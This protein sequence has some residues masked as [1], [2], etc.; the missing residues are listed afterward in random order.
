MFGETE[1][2]VMK[3]PLTTHD[4]LLY[5][6]WNSLHGEFSIKIF[7]RLSLNRVPRT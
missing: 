3:D 7:I 1:V 2:F 6:F 4:T 5:F